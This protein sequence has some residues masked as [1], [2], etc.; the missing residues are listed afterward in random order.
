MINTICTNE[1]KNLYLNTKLNLHRLAKLKVEAKRKLETRRQ[2]ERMKLIERDR[3]LG[4]LKILYN[5]WSSPSLG[6]YNL[7]Y[8]A[9]TA[10]VS[11]S[12]CHISAFR[13]PI[14]QSLYQF[15]FH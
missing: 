4:L 7:D 13:F 11:H 1:E 9:F 12:S 15:R 6:F 14:R 10:L 5:E 2:E 8:V 3:R